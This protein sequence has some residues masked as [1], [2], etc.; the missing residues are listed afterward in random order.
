MPRPDTP[1]ERPRAN[2]IFDDARDVLGSL[3][4]LRS[5]NARPVTRDDAFIEHGERVR[6][7]VTELDQDGNEITK[8]VIKRA[9]DIVFGPI[10]RRALVSDDFEQGAA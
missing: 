1:W 3:R 10:G 5:R 7:Y 6:Y 2:S 8:Q 4:G 9:V